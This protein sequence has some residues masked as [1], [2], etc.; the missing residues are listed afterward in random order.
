ML[1][2]CTSLIK[3]SV[4]CKRSD[5]KNASADANWSVVYPRERMKLVVA[6]RN[7]S[8]SSTI[9]ITGE[10][11]Y[12]IPFIGT[13]IFNLVI[14]GS[15]SRRGGKV[16]VMFSDLV[17]SAAKSRGCSVTVLSRPEGVPWMLT[18]GIDRA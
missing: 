3:Q 15:S 14:S 11:G 18:L 12:T 2:V 9:A 4:S 17:A 6:R 7:E 16:T 5:F 1:G 13:A 8:S 10:L